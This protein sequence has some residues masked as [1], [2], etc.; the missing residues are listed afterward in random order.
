MK[1]IALILSLLAPANPALAADRLAC[2]V[3]GKVAPCPAGATLAIGQK[4]SISAVPTGTSSL[5]VTIGN[6]ARICP[7]STA[8]GD[9]YYGTGS[10]CAILLAGST[11]QLLHANG[12]GPTTWGMVDLAADVTGVLPLA[13]GGTAVDNTNI[14]QNAIFAGPPSGGAGNAGWRAAV[15]LD[16]PPVAGVAG[17]YPTAGQIITQTVDGFGRINT[18]SST[19]VLTSPAIGGSPTITGL[20]SPTPGS[21]QA[22]TALYAEAQKTGGPAVIGLSSGA[23]AANVYFG[24][25]ASVEG[26]D[27]TAANVTPFSAPAAGTLKNC[28]LYSA[29]AAGTATNFTVHRATGSTNSPSFAAT[30]IVIAVGNGNKYGSDTTHSAA[31]S[32]LDLFVAKTDA[33]FGTTRLAIICQLVPTT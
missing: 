19:N 21:S 27:A 17:S 25:A 28:S 2:Q 6:D 30:A 8:A 13:R 12:A 16:L 7:V 10:A 1:K 5:T 20:P 33:N 11:H 18:I 15:S 4:I 3:A 29:A 31:V 24:P 9:T 14:A 23:L 26:Y 22:A 32:A